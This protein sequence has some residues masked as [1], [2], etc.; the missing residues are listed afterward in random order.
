MKLISLLSL[1]LISPVFSYESR[2]LGDIEM[3]LGSTS[4]SDK[5]ELVSD[6]WLADGRLILEHRS[7]PIRL[8]A[9]LDA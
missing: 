8:L 9:Q 4:S 6:A 1:L 2:V 5:N 7:D 3:R